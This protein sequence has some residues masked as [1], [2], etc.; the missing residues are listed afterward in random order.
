M[1]VVIRLL[2]IRM[3]P[4]PRRFRV[5]AR[6]ISM[7]TERGEKKKKEEELDCRCTYMESVIRPVLCDSKGAFHRC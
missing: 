4:V 5:F 1:Q 7:Q 3:D 2:A 6:A